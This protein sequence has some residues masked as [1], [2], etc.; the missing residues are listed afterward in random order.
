[1][2][3]FWAK[4]EGHGVVQLSLSPMLSWKAPWGRCL[5]AFS[6]TLENW[7]TNSCKHLSD[8]LVPAKSANGK[9]MA[10]LFSLLSLLSLNAPWLPDF[11]QL[12]KQLLH[13]FNNCSSSSLNCCQVSGTLKTDGSSLQKLISCGCACS[14]CLLVLLHSL[15][16]FLCNSSSCSMLA[17]CSEAVRHA[18]WVTSPLRMLSEKRTLQCWLQFSLTYCFFAASSNLFLTIESG[19]FLSVMIP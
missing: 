18:P 14:L 6:M 8:A 1:M 13:C 17:V 5:I 2:H 12:S 15:Q 19:L 3:F 7:W 9:G 10:W 11:F 16:I 4:L